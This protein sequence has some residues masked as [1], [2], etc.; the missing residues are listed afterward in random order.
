[1]MA[2]GWTVDFFKTAAGR[3]PVGDFFAGLT[4]KDAVDFAAVVRAL[5]ELGA[6]L[7]MPHSKPLG[8]GLFELR[9]GRVRVFYVFQGVKRAVLVHAYLKQGQ[10]APKGEI[11]VARK[12]A[13]E[14]AG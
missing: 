4:R 2:A 13:R 12:R 3:Q 11:E 6:A 1:M 14:I 5:G 8:D 10:K 9:A 7:R